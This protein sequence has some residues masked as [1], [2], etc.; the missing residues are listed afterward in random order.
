MYSEEREEM[1]DKIGRQIPSS[2]DE[3]EEDILEELSAMVRNR[4]L[5]PVQDLCA[6]LEMSRRELGYY[7]RKMAEH[8]YIE[9]L[10]RDGNIRVTELGRIT[11]AQC[12]HRHETFVQLLQLVGVRGDTAYEDACRIEHVVTEET[13]QQVSNFVNYGDTFERVLRYIDLKYRYQPGDYPFL[14]GLYYNEKSYP[15]DFAREFEYFSE[16]VVLHV[17]EE[18]SYFMLQ[19]LGELPAGLQLRCQDRERG[20]VT[21]E[22]RNGCPCIPSEVFEYAIQD[23][24]P[25]TEGTALVAFV[26][27]G[28]QPDE[29]KSRELDVHIW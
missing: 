26:K 22:V 27:E 12:R 19:P 11:G 25:I 18:H 2:R 21:A 13:V 5:I 15:R 8:G 16:T 24:D 1:K 28:E 20:W 23:Q 14:M 29:T 10:D 17:E 6:S 7:L 4:E 3:I 9:E